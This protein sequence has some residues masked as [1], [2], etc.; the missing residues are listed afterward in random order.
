MCNSVCACRMIF[1][2]TTDS[3]Q[4]LWSWQSKSPSDDRWKVESWLTLGFC[5]WF[6]FRCLSVWCLWNRSASTSF[7]YWTDV[8]TLFVYTSSI[9]CCF[10]LQTVSDPCWQTASLG[11]LCRIWHVNHT[12]ELVLLC[13]ATERQYNLWKCGDLS[14]LIT[15]KQP[16]EVG[17]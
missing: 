7:F 16:T 12:R 10:P 14:H 2:R 1:E 11:N 3:D 9:S 4:L 17:D 8:N 13:T 6:Y 5:V 15:S